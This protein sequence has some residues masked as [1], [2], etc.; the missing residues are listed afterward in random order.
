MSCLGIV[1]CVLVHSF[2]NTIYFN[3]CFIEAYKIIFKFH[4]SLKEIVCAILNIIPLTLNKIRIKRQN[5]LTVTFQE[6]YLPIT[7]LRKSSLLKIMQNML[8]IN[9]KIF[10]KIIEKSNRNA[11]WQRCYLYKAQRRSSKKYFHRDSIF[12]CPKKT[13]FK[14]IYSTSDWHNRLV[15]S[16]VR[17]FQEKT[18]QKVQTHDILTSLVWAA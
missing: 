11:I 6:N 5:F 16:R 4:Q 12:L 3:F 14:K 10:K 8:I 2:W 18:Y 17:R 15:S 13:V 9:K 7:F 1:K